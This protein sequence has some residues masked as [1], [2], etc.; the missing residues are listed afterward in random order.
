MNFFSFFFCSVESFVYYFY[1]KIKKR[2]F[3]VAFYQKALQKYMSGFETTKNQLPKY[4]N[5]S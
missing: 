2:S 4:S 5:F 3:F 1:L